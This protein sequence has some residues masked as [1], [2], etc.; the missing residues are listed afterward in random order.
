MDFIQFKKFFETEPKYRLGQAQTGLF[1]ELIGDWQETK[2]LPAVLKEELN[3][4][5]P[6]GIL[7]ETFESKDDN[8]LKALI[9]LEDG[10]KIETVLMRH[11]D[12]RNT[13]CV[14][15]QFGCAMNC[16]FCATG[17]MGFKRNLTVWEIVEQVL[18][19]A[20]HL[21]KFEERVSGIV[22]MGMGEPFL[23]YENVMGA[24]RVLNDKDGFNLGARHISIS[25]AGIIEGIE[26]LAEEKLQVN[27][28]ISL[29]APDNELRS[30]LMPINKNYSLEKVLKAVNDYV[31]KTKRKV[32]FEYVMIRDVNDSEEQAEAL[33]KLMKNYLYFINLISYNPTGIFKPSSSEQIKI[34]KEIL[35]KRGVAVTQRHRFGQDIE[36]ACGQLAGK[37]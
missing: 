17:K 34:F 20:R 1:R 2:S 3:K 21:K 6:I 32:M 7:A 13:I 10:L 14:S 26:K 27:L 11:S 36:G 19:F 35:E 30:K 18:F 24:I 29:H 4:K 37:E 31:Q 15:S 9:T 5:F 28:A 12:K 25:T 33:A 22:F 8:T 16:A 23:N